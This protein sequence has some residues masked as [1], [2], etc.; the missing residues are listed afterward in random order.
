V[1]AGYVFNTTIAG[2]EQADACLI[3]GSNPRIEAPIVNLRLRKRHMIGRFPV[4]VIGPRADLTYKTQHLGAGPE[5]LQQVADGGHAFCKTLEA[6]KTPMLILGQGALAR[7]DGARVLGTARRI[8]ER[9][10]MIQ[11]DW[12]GFN[13]L[14]TAAARVGA[15]DLGF[16]GG[17]VEGAEFVYL[18]GADELDMAKLDRAFVVYQGHHGDAGAH[19]ADVI[20]PGAAYT[21]KDATWVNTEGRVQRGWRAVFP[22]GDA[23]E[24]WTI[25]RAL[26]AALGRALPYDDID[27]LRRRIEDINPVLGLLGGIGRAEWGEF[28]E[29]GAMEPTPFTPRIANFYMTDPISRASETMAQCSRAFGPGARTGTDG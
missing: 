8:A 6:A 25:I 4:G 24:D 21:E 3:V 28:G 26:S 12:N 20:L 14:H 7:P 11:P 1:R 17:K 2:I 13:V 10:N 19:R 18:L 16:A 9:F 15:L 27:A 23:R 29:A 22:P 5:T